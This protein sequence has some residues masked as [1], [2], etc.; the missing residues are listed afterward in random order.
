MNLH[1][2]PIVLGWRVGILINVQPPNNTPSTPLFF[3]KER[4]FFGKF[5]KIGPL[6]LGSSSGEPRARPYS[7]TRCHAKVVLQGVK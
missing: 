4:Y 3:I 2:V 7:F 6:F 5:S 1:T